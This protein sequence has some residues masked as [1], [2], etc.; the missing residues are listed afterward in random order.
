MFWSMTKA[1]YGLRNRPLEWNDYSYGIVIPLF[2]KGLFH[3][4]VIPIWI[5]IP[6]QRR[7]HIPLKNEE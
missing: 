2:G 5:S 3:G 1:S 4:I 6:I 7:I